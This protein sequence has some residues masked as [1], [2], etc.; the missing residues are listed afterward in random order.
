MVREQCFGESKLIAARECALLLQHLDYSN[1]L[2]IMMDNVRHFSLCLSLFLCFS[3][4][5]S[6][7]IT[8]SPLSQSVLEFFLNI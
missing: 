4:P 8:L 7:S 1:T 6:L 3:L 2:S 5:L